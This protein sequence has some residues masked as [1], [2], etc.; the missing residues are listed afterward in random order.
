MATAVF[1]D[2]NV[3]VYA[4]EHSEPRK[5]A[6]AVRLLR[7]LD[8][9][10]VVISSQVLSE[11]ASV[12]THPVKNFLPIREVIDGVL[13]MQTA[14]RVVPVDADV[15]IA[16]LEARERWGL[17]YYDAQIW[18][19][20][21]RNA[22]PSPTGLCWARSGSRTRS[23]TG[24]TW[25]PSWRAPESASRLATRRRCPAAP[26]RRR[27]TARRSRRRRSARSADA[28]SAPR[29]RRPRCR[30]RAR[31]RRNPR[32]GVASASSCAR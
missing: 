7:R 13:R 16:A 17:S 25:T 28:C 19:A 10:S 20:A 2:T 4:E 22:V 23:R 30:P 3:L 8:P 26:A 11:Y 27:T 31:S 1:A 29:P 32:T 5:N 18:A 24:S 6:A 14:W 12:L 9:E 21:A 15:V